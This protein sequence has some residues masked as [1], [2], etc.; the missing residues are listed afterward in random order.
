VHI[1]GEDLVDD[2]PKRPQDWGGWLLGPGIG[3]RLGL[4]QDLTN[5]PPGVMKPA[6]DLADGQAIASGAANQYARVISRGRWS[7]TDDR[8]NCRWDL[9]L[10][11]IT[12]LIATTKSVVK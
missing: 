6:R 1:V 10:I 4:S 5:L 11:L 3:L 12:P 7:A 8:P 9:D 2:R